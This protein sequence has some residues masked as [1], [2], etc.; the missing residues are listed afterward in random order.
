[1]KNTRTKTAKRLKKQSL[2]KEL[3]FNANIDISIKRDAELAK[4]RYILANSRSLFFKKIKPG[5]YRA[6]EPRS[7]YTVILDGLLLQAGNSII[8]ITDS[9]SRSLIIAFN[10]AMKK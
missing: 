4:V 5:V 9:E 2:I 10:K 8:S 1:M 3:A 7:N 6:I